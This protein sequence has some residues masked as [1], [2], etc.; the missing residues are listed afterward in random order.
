MYV[1]QKIISDAFIGHF[2][3]LRVQIAGSAAVTASVRR[4]RYPLALLAVF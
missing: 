4:H 1:N 3:A 2:Q